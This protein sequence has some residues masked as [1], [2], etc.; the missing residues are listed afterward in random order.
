MSET[1]PADREPATEPLAV[2]EPAP[3][4]TT[5]DQAGNTHR[6][7]DYLGQWVVL[8]FYPRD[9][10]PGCTKQACQF[11]DASSELQSRD[12]V[13]LG[14]SPQGEQSHQKFADKQR[15]SFPLLV[16]SD[17]A[18][19]TAFGVY[20]EKTSFGKTGLGIVRTTFLIDPRGKVRERFDKVKVDGHSDAVLQKLD[21]LQG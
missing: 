11:R 14:V 1:S 21:A 7:S 16:D 15:L 17:R 20:R 8:Y 13:V 6:L 18:I 3:D 9:N 19:A 10:T 4:F 5:T 2:G 12:A